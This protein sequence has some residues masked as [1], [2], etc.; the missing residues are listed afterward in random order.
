MIAQQCGPS[1]K[2]VPGVF[3][4]TKKTCRE[5]FLTGLRFGKLAFEFLGDAVGEEEFQLW[6]ARKG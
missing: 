5:S 2:N 1:D 3:S 4:D 6:L